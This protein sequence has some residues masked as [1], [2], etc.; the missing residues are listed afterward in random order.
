MRVQRY[1]IFCK[2]QS[3]RALKTEKFISNIFYIHKKFK[4]NSL[5][6][7]LNYTFYPLDIEDKSLAIMSK[8]EES[9]K[10]K[11]S[12]EGNSKKK[13]TKKI[14]YQYKP[15][16]IDL[17]AWQVL[18]RKQVAQE[19]N[20]VIHCI[21]EKKVPGEYQVKNPKTNQ[22]YKVVYRGAQSP[23]NYC[24]C[25]DFKTSCLGTCKHLEAL[26]LWLARSRHHVHREIP[27]YTSV[28]LDYTTERKVR[29]RI[30]GD[31]KEA[32]TKLASSFFDNQFILE[33][34]SFE[35]FDAFL[36]KA[37]KIDDTFRCYRDA[38][39]FVI[40][41]REHKK[42]IR[43][44]DALTKDDF[45]DLL[46]TNLYPYQEEGVRFAAKAG[47]T[48]IADEMGLGKTIQAIGTA[49]LLR[50]KGLVNSTL[51]ICPTSLKYQWERE[52]EQFTKQQVHVIEG[53][54]LKRKEQ[55]NVPEPYKIISYNAV[56]NDIKI[57]GCLETDMVIIDEVQR[58]KNWDTQIAKAARKINSQYVV[59]LSGTPLENR[60]EELFSVMELVDQ[61][62]LGPYYQFRD[63]YIISDN[64]GATIGYRNLN[65]IGQ[66]LKPYL[67]RRRKQTVK[68]QLPVRQDKNLMV[69]MTKEQMA[70]HNEAKTH[71]S[72]LLQK[73][74][75]MHFLSETDRN[76]IILLLQQMRMVC[77]STYILDQKTRFDTK[78]DE[79]MNIISNTIE[80]GEEKIVVFSQ[81]ERMTRLVAQEM[82]H[83]GIRYE[84]LHGGIP[85]K[86]RKD[87]VNNFTDLPDCRVFLSTDAGSTGLNLQAA[88]VIINMDLPWNPATL[89]QRI[90]RI[91]RIG[92][93]RNIQVINL[94]SMLTFEE[95]MLGKLKFKSSMFEGVLDGGEDT[96]F[97]QDTKFQ[98]I[99]E[100]LNETINKPRENRTKY[101]VPPINKD[102]EESK[103]SKNTGNSHYDFDPL[104]EEQADNSPTV[105]ANEEHDLLPHQNQIP[106][107]DKLIEQGI[108]FFTGLAETLKSPTATQVLVNQILENDPETGET[109]IKIPVPNKETVV[110]MLGL[111]SKILSS[112]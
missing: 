91:Y 58:L 87:L 20:L 54:H 102:E 83:T 37:R 45:K 95:D 35:N 31:N 59:V 75:K 10:N 67:I 76:K 89:E 38:L 93:T 94:I 66:R 41:H 92:Q 100:D 34:S 73:W 2:A 48:I 5:L 61:F 36:K 62:C 101:E 64:K 98:K 6:L 56:C 14:P 79:A 106:Q 15:D 26:K 33:E 96:I 86:T 82:D 63:R 17:K 49:E 43:W 9:I 21:D 97:T 72:R 110:Q 44:I 27:S 90:A 40:E 69:P 7:Q 85:S 53:N 13:Q 78:I 46:Q 71:V 107:S 57:F 111:I 32:F 25:L 104:F 39:Q 11:K 24:S 60:L 55:Y 103:I 65:E 8:Q 99:M 84:Y 81:W 18:L 108:T 30:G 51:I 112:K 29:I 88:S 16:D 23:W 105:N 1:T 77:D 4:T 70:I 12:A 28:Y 19:E 74:E 22:E 47:R 80:S 50:K 68:L 52:I 109:N 42:R 3:Q